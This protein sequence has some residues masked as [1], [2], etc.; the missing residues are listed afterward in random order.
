MG[1]GSYLLSSWLFLRLLGLIY[2]AAF[3][4]LGAQINGLVG[5]RGI[6]PA[7]DFL[8][9]KQA[10]G[11]S[12]FWQ[13]PTLCWWNRSDR[14]LQFLCWGGAGLAVLLGLGVAPVLTLILLWAA[15]LSLFSV[16]RIFLSYQW[17]ILLLET[18]FLAI[19]IAPFELLPTFPPA[20][21]PSPVMLGLLRWLL[22]RLMFSSGFAK[23]RS[24][25]RA[26]RNLTA[27]S[28]HYETQP[29][30][31]WTAW[32]VHRLP[33][34]FHKL[35]IVLM[36]AGELL[37]PMLIFLPFP[38]RYAA[39]VAFVVLMLL[40]MATGN[41][42]FFNLLGI[43]LSILLFDDAVW[44]ACLRKLFPNFSLDAS[45][46]SS[47][48][49]LWITVP[50]ALIVLLLSVEIICRL[51][52]Y[53][54]RWPRWLDTVVVWLEPFRLVNPYGLFAVMTTERPEIIVEGSHDG[55]NWEAYE[56]K[57]KP[58]EVRRRPRFVAP[59]QP[60]LDWQMW[61]A[62]LSFYQSNPWFGQFLARLL[63]GSPEVSALLKENAFTDKP[64]R[65]IRAALYN[66]QFSDFATRRAAGAWWQRERRGLYSPVLSSRDRS[67][68]P[69][70]PL[71]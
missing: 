23:L 61:F 14:F 25:D 10:W 28:Y 62:A 1:S 45:S 13:V 34:W 29:L 68:E 26:W 19:F 6:L 58:G 67:K 33:G 51:V 24:G 47:G 35:S 17:D 11:R 57:W 15:Y 49:S 7:R 31:P 4:S 69:G 21:G 50:V 39:G 22:F 70:L 55:V 18:G 52:R 20:T 53:P 64:P 27:L 63:Q 2:F 56:F 60:R 12:R 37:A 71:N 43:A 40:I 38:C 16:C 42:C 59:H 9:A 5:S 36:F 30:P 46:V 8:L 32:Y 3:V 48:W 66:Y 65:F 54:L 44:L 41:Y